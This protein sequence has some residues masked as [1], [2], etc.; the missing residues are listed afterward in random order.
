MRRLALAFLLAGARALLAQPPLTLND[1]LARALRDN[2]DVRTARLRA[3]SAHAEQRIARALPPLAIATIPA[4]PYQYSVGA[5]LDVGPQRLYRTRVAGLGLR[6]AHS[7]TVDARRQ[8]VFAV[9]Q[10]FYDVLLSEALRVI[11]SEQRDIFRQLLAADSARYRSGDVPARDVTKSEVELARADA[12]LTRADAQVHA[13]RLALQL[14][15]GSE[16]P[17]GA[18]RVGA[19]DEVGGL[20]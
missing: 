4:V 6:A 8:V 20:S 12:D 9:R 14:L 16:R 10:A 15:M 5:P 13:T 7:D 18:V 2:P 1:V 3:D 11:T 19:G 17:H